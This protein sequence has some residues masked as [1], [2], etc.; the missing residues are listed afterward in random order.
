MPNL[1]NV[2]DEKD[3]PYNYGLTQTLKVGSRVFQF[4]QLLLKDQGLF[5][6]SSVDRIV[7]ER[8]IYLY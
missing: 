8:N 2:N 4:N 7:I 3:N 1:S 6:R 5:I